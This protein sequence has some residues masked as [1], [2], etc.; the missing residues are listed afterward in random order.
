MA[1]LLGSL[2]GTVGGVVQG[3]GGVVSGLGG[4]VSGVGGVLNPTPPTPEPEPEK[5]VRIER[6]EVTRD[7]D[8]KV[9]NVGAW[10]YQYVLDEDTG[11]VVAQNP[12]PEGAT[13]Q[14][15]D[16]GVYA[17]GSRRPINP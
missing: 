1:G 10:D 13:T 7:A 6:D 5:P 14:E 16:I 15:E 11:E 2:V 12:K 17:D 8:G 3:A 9:I 4:V